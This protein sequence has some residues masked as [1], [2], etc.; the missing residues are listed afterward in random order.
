MMP[1]FCKIPTVIKR[2]VKAGKVLLNGTKPKG[3][4]SKTE[5]N[6]IMMPL[7]LLAV[8]LTVRNLIRYGLLIFSKKRS[9]FN[10]LFN[11]LRNFS[12]EN[13]LIL[14]GLG[15]HKLLLNRLLIPIKNIRPPNTVLR[16]GIDTGIKNITIYS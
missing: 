7:I 5:P 14:I 11:T 13:S 6:K 9:H 12:P 15:S 3:N 1:S 10:P 16:P 2:I 4:M 8:L